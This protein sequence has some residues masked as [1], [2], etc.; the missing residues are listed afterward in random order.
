MEKPRHRERGL[1]THSTSAIT[2]APNSRIRA[3][4]SSVSNTMI[5]V[6]SDP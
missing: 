6:A 1:L 3:A 5:A 2:S 4:A